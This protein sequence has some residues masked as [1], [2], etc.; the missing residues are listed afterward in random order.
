M[1]FDKEL[2]FFVQRIEPRTAN[3][4]DVSKKA[5]EF[6]FPSQLR[7][8]AKTRLIKLKLKTVRIENER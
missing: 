2:L 4:K 1:S 8:S 3:I 6:D 5:E 7:T